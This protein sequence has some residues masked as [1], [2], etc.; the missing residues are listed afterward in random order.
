MIGNEIIR[1]VVI[2]QIGKDKVTEADVLS[3][4]ELDLSGQGLFEVD[5][6]SRFRNLEKLNL[7]ENCLS[8]LS[9]ISELKGLKE[10][11][12]GND[13]FLSNEEKAACGDNDCFF[14]KS[15]DRH[16]ISAFFPEYFHIQN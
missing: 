15:I 16:I 5:D 14:Y 6:I 2:E 12:I 1:K 13:P 8:E 7:T 3:L 9:C 10:L 4:K 11:R